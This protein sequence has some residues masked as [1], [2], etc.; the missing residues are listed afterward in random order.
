MN[1]RKYLPWLIGGGLFLWNWVETFISNIDYSIIGL[2]KNQ[3][4]MQG[5]VLEFIF[6][7]SNGNQTGFTLID[8][9]GSI[10]YQN[11]ELSKFYQNVPIE[12][13][14]N[15]IVQLP[16]KVAIKWLQALKAIP[17][18]IQDFQTKNILL[19]FVGNYTFKIFGISYTV[20][21]NY[22]IPLSV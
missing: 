3:L 1:F 22:K 20:P 14:P 7:L 18:L 11:I 2:K 6:N 16:V 8:I 4:D 19:D 21:F 13:Y 5:V 12:S 15:S 17:N 10:F 9:Q